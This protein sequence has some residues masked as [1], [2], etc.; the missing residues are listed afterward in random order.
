V[1]DVTPTLLALMGLPIGA[2]MD[3]RVMRKAFRRGF[4]YEHP[5]RYVSSY[6]ANVHADD[7]PIES[8]MDDQILERLRAL[9]YIE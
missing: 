6:D 5:V 3:G 4:L 2:D 9:G 7:V 1:L 8:P